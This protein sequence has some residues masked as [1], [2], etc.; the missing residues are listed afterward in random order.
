M[1]RRLKQPVVY[2][3]YALISILVVGAGAMLTIKHKVDSTPVSNIIEEFDYVSKSI[4][5]DFSD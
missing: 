2:S 4:F 5:E 3:L 1:K